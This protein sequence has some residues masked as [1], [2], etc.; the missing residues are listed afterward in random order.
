MILVILLSKAVLVKHQISISEI[1][2]NSTHDFEQNNDPSPIYDFQ[3]NL[4]RLYQYQW[5]G[6][7]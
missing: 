7:E 5:I 6:L 4:I 1:Y 2:A 3:Y